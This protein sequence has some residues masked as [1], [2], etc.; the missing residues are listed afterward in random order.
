[1]NC[2]ACRGITTGRRISTPMRFRIVTVGLIPSRN[3]VH[4]LADGQ[5]FASRHAGNPEE[6][7]R[8]ATQMGDTRQ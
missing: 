5:I 6:L 3:K 4:C 1:M 7:H 8:P 2:L